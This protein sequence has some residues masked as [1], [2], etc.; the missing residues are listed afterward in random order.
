MFNFI[1]ENELYEAVI[2]GIS[3]ICSDL[4]EGCEEEAE[5]IAKVYEDKKK[6]M[7]VFMIQ[8]G[9]VDLFGL[10]TAESALAKLGEPQVD[11]DLGMV[12]FPDQTFD[13]THSIAVEYDG[14]L[15]EFTEVMLDD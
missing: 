7:A 3:F 14:Y 8:N 6:D 13:D 9:L 2:N 5:N 11:L 10:Q 1:E 15:D 12:T 4:Y